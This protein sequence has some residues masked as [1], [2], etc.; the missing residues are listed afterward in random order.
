MSKALLSGMLAL[1][2]VA[3][4]SGVAKDNAEADK[5]AVASRPSAPAMPAERT[6]A[7][8]TRIGARIE[9]SLSSR[10]DKAG[11]TVAA[12]VSADVK[13]ANGHVVIPSGSTVE[14]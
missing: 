5:A 11:Q 7:S 4:S 9:D 2:L 8:G 14:I 6:L 1:G 12:T 3:C 10:H 13:D